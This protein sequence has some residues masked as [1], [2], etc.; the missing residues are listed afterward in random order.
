MIDGASNQNGDYCECV[1]AHNL[2]NIQTSFKE[3]S[4]T[5]ANSI[6]LS[7]RQHLKCQSKLEI[8]GKLRFY[9]LHVAL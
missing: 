7:I 9:T 4:S 5:F 8:G 6:A 2:G 3:L 1:D